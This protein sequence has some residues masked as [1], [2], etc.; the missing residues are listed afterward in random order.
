MSAASINPSSEPL[1]WRAWLETHGSK[2]L[3]FARQQTRSEQDAEDIFQNALVKLAKKT[4]S[5]EFSGGQEAW[6]PYLYT[7]LRREAIDLGRKIDRRDKREQAVVE[8]Q[9]ALSGS[10]RDPWFESS[11]DMKERADILQ[12]ALQAL[13]DK[14]SEVVVMKI[15]GDQTFADIGEAL[16]ISINTAA[17]RYRYGLEALR[18]RLSAQRN[19]GEI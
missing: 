7:Q 11:A 3:L 1:S 15:W 19:T 13:P 8:D 6:L 16:D 10:G 4:S 9:K 18:K 12:E 2:L 5:G 14:F 17:S